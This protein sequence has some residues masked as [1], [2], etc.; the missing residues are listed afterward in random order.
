MSTTCNTTAVIEP[1]NDPADSPVSSTESQTT[2][3]PKEP[4]SLLSFIRHLIDHNKDLEARV[5]NLEQKLGWSR[6]L[7]GTFGVFL[8]MN[9]F[10]VSFL[11][12]Y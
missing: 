10:L 12:F 6:F 7:Y 4:T 2:E 1:T 9:L 5:A 8:V 3:P 11:Y